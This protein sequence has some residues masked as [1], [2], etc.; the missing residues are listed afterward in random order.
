[1]Q[2]SLGLGPHG[3][4][5]SWARSDLRPYQWG[6]A[7][8]L[9]PSALGDTVQVGTHGLLPS[10]QGKRRFSWLLP[11]GRCRPNVAG[12][13]CDSCA[14]GFHGYPHCLPC[15][16]HEAGTAPSIC[17]PL[18]G[19]CHCKVSSPLAPSCTSWLRGWPRRPARVPAL[20]GSFGDEEVTATPVPGPLTRVALPL[21]QENVQGPRCDQCR[22]GTFS[23]EAANPKGCTRCF[24]FGATERCRSSVHARHEV[25][26]WAPGRAP[27]W[28]PPWGEHTLL[29]RETGTQGGPAV[30]THLV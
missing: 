24:C 4:G 23:L 12:R 11:T 13:R 17:D 27:G 3:L 18:T 5:W 7:C 15:R 8:V 28:A 21:P 1:M 29:P 30:G 16:C 26:S 25:A 14:P 10:E 2:V 6:P 20:P 22:L 19:R 9:L